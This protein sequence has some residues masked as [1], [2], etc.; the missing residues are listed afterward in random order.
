[1]LYIA[2]CS[3]LGAIT[4]T[5][6]SGRATIPTNAQA[7]PVLAIERK[8]CAPWQRRSVGRCRRAG[9]HGYPI[10]DNELD[11]IDARHSLNRQSMLI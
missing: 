5:A 2:A 10:Y 4:S 9:V 7:L 1:V 11:V 3:I 8:N 6:N